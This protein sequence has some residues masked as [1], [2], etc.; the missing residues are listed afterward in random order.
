MSQQGDSNNNKEFLV[1]EFPHEIKNGVTPMAIVPNNWII[2]DNLGNLQCLWPN[3]KTNNEFAKAVCNKLQIDKKD[4]QVCAI[5][6]K[7]KTNLYERATEKLRELEQL[8]SSQSSG[9]TSDEEE[10]NQ[11]RKVKRNR[12]YI[13]SLSDDDSDTENIPKIPDVPSK[14]NALDK[15][16]VRSDMKNTTYRSSEVTQNIDI[17]SDIDP[18]CDAD[19][20]PA[21]PIF[22]TKHCRSIQSRSSESYRNSE[23]HADQPSPRLVRIPS[24]QQTNNS[25]NYSNVPGKVSSS[26]ISGS[27]D[28]DS[29][30]TNEV[31]VEPIITFSQLNKCCQKTATMVMKLITKVEIMSKDLQYITYMLEK[32][33]HEPT[34]MD[35]DNPYLKDLP[36]MEYGHLK[37]FNDV[38]EGEE[39]FMNIC[40]QYSGIGGRDLGDCTRRLLNKILSHR[41]TLEMNW[42]GRNEKK[43][44][45]EHVNIRKLIL[46]VVRKYFKNATETETE[47]IIKQWLRSAGDREGGRDRRRKEHSN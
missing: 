15:K 45:K 29:T 47:Q 13:S 5:N 19:V 24:A 27:V 46:A 11:K 18:N 23:R 10:L 36:A 30:I 12:K 28:L 14:Q 6:I 9:P 1:V 16:S 25:S 41:L 26:D 43:C 8:L 34:K 3:L 22:F 17:S 4:C 42:S 44:F 2:V 31:E 33:N 20:I 7:Y 40:A 38:L 32:M 37:E 35:S 39:V 21:M